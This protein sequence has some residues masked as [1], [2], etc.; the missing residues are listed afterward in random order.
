MGAFVRANSSIADDFFS[1][2]DYDDPK[3]KHFR[4]LD[5]RINYLNFRLS[6]IGYGPRFRAC[7]FCNGLAG[8]RPVEDDLEVLAYGVQKTQSAADDWER[9][10]LL[11]PSTIDSAMHTNAVISMPVTK[12]PEKTKGK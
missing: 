12:V 8:D 9:K 1:K 5:K 4:E 11:S 6:G 7:D 3:G 10:V 2:G